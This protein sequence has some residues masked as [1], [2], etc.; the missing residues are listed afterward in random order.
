MNVLGVILARAGSKGLPD[1]CLRDLLGRE[2]LAY[3]FDHVAASRRL[4]DS[5]FTSDSIP[6]LNLA[7]KAGI[8]AIERPAELA[9][10]VSTV[11]AVARHAVEYWEAAHQ[12]QVDCI[13]LL[14]GNIPVREIDLIDRAVDHLIRTG[15]DSVRS[16]ARVSKQHPDWIHRVDEDRMTQFRPNSIYRRQD[17]EPLY[18]HDG[19]VAAITRQS[20]FDALKTPDDKQSFLGKDR[21]A[22]IQNPQDAVDIDD[23]VDMYMAEAILRSKDNVPQP[24]HTNPVESAPV[25]TIK[26]KCIGIDH[27]TFIIAEAG[28]NHNGDVATACKMIDAAV[29]AKADAIKFQMFQAQNLVTSTATLANYQQQ[30]CKEDSQQALLSKL[31][32]SYDAFKQIK[33]YC[34][35]LGIIFLA[36]P[37]GEQEV[38]QLVSLDAAAIKIA[39]TDLIN[40]PLLS[41]A[42]STQLPLIV[43]IG[44]STA[45]EII[46]SVRHL[47]QLGVRERLILLHCVSQYPTPLDHAN[48]GAIAALQKEFRVPCGFSDHTTSTQTGAWAVAAGACI[49]EKHFTLDPSQP[50]P[51]H[52]M[53][54]NPDQLA[55]Y[56]ENVRI[57]ERANGSGR[58]GM[59]EIEADIRTSAGRSVVASRNIPAGTILAVDMLALKRPGTGMMP[60]E[61]EKLIGKCTSIDI[62]RDTLFEWEMVQ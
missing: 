7:R 5:V 15:A 26:N 44:A 43:S 20:L 3:T 53:S 13:V 42:A 12:Q 10:D 35:Q 60:Q 50:G 62:P 52:A 19:A 28:V 58:F 2:V 29:L 36:T 16:V 11:D 18:Y 49:L 51:D 57:A 37:F 48:L 17:L 30:N 45:T 40:H 54:L 39:S 34:D 33:Q 31:E 55:E 61:M 27:P 59:T 47:D 56:I 24:C 38:E 21:R 8:A 25:I 4:T 41:S 6:A 32:L 9:S 14:Y 1:K 46:E 23:P 22:L